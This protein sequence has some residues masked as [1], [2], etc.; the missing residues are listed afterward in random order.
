[1]PVFKIKI[2][3]VLNRLL[4]SSLYIRFF[5]TIVAAWKPLY[6][7]QLY[8]NKSIVMYFKVTWLASSQ[9]ADAV[10]FLPQSLQA[11]AWTVPQNFVKQPHSTF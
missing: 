6:R 8:S 1:M 9:V 3:I 7:A 2:L 5:S 10:P 4:T 11:K